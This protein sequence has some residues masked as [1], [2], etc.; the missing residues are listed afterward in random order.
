MCNLALSKSRRDPHLPN[1]RQTSQKSLK[2][3]VSVKVT[4]T[5]PKAAPP[6]LLLLVLKLLRRW[7]LRLLSLPLPEPSG[8]PERLAPGFRL[9]FP[10][11]PVVALELRTERLVVVVASVVVAGEGPAPSTYREA[12]KCRRPLPQKARRVSQ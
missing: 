4:L 5:R 7:L 6:V 8:E 10:E 12:A 11:V 9:S 3:L 2:S 1:R